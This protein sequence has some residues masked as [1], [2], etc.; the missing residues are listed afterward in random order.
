MCANDLFN[1]NFAAR[2][3]RRNSHDLSFLLFQT[4]LE[5]IL[6][7]A[8]SS[9][10]KAKKAMVDAARLADELRVEQE[11]VQ[12]QDKARKAMEGQ[13][14]ELQQRLEIAENEALKGS[15][16]AIAKLEDRIRGLESELDLEQRRHG[17]AQK[18]MR[19]ADRRVKKWKKKFPPKILTS[20]M[21]WCSHANA[22][23]DIGE[24]TRVSGGW[25]QEEP[26][27]DARSCWEAAAKD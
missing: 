21:E 17:D 18:N 20:V 6:N 25:R 1:F 24:G 13:I 11:F 7:E 2:D 5:E 4:D 27:K 3:S 22:N 8:K 14:K 15:K 23:F 19:K 16:K 9:E 10:E 12:S 26:R